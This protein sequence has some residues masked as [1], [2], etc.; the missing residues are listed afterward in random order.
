MLVFSRHAFRSLRQ[1]RGLTQKKL[2]EAIGTT[3]Q[4]V[5]LWEY[6]KRTPTAD[7]LLRAMVLLGCT[8]QDLLAAPQS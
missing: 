2:G 5:Q 4:H 6:G 1:A 7:Y 3:E 8:P